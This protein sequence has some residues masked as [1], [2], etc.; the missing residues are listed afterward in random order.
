M[1]RTAVVT[2]EG[3]GI[4][5]ACAEALVKEGYTVYGLSRTDRGV[6][7]VKHIG[8][9]VTDTSALKAAF[10]QIKDESG[11]VGLLVTCAGMGVSGAVEFIGEEDTKRQFEVN[12]F[13]TLNTV[14][15]ALPYMRKNQSGRIIMISSVAAEYSIPFQVYYSMSKA[16]INSLAAGL[17]NEVRQFGISVC[18]LMPGDIKTGFTGSRIKAHEGDDIFG[19]AI[20]RSVAV[21]ERD[22]QNGMPPEAIAKKVVALSKKKKVSPL[23]TA[24]AAYKLMVF[25]KRILPAAAVNR[26]VGMLY[27]K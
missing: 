8:C 22:E 17:A 4:G 21:M 3:S 19:G 23:Y 18:A 9:D 15:A 11:A 25:A 6:A 1:I 16:S 24:G 10:A 12:L 5:K 27:I 7:G 14:R 13:G 2:G 26:I 20:T